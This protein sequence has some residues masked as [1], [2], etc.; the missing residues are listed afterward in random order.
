MPFTSDLV[1]EIN[2]LIK[3][4]LSTSQE[5]IKVHKT[6][7]KATIDATVRLFEKGL[8]TQDDGGYLTFAGR[9]TAEHAQ[10]LHDMLTLGE[11]QLID[12]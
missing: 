9:E 4:N 10:A 3:Y 6:A 7:A 5:G 1:E 2:V 8:I 12:S 11:A